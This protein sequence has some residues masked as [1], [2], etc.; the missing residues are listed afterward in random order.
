MPLPRKFDFFAE[1]FSWGIPSLFEPHLTQHTSHSGIISIRC[2]QGRPTEPHNED[3]S[4]TGASIYLELSKVNHESF[5]R[6]TFIKTVVRDAELNTSFIY[7]ARLSKVMVFRDAS[8]SRELYL[9]VTMAS[10]SQRNEKLRVN[11]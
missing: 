9:A 6:C 1:F 7:I 3:S 5:I 11:Q 8:S 10:L 2:F 4:A